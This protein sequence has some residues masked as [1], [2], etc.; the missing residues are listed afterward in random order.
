ML[1]RQPRY[2]PIGIDVGGASLKM[3]QLV[4]EGGAPSVATAA[5][6]VIPSGVE[7]AVPR[8][9][10]IQRAIADALRRHPFHGRAV[11]S[12]LGIRDFQMKSVRM[13]RMP[14]SDL[15]SAVKFEAQ[16]R[17]DLDPETSQYRFITA[18]EVR[19]G[20]ELKEEVIVFAVP[21]DV[22]QARLDLLEF[23]KL[24]PAAIDITP[25]AVARS[26]FRYLRRAED[27]HA[28]NVF[29]DV[30]LCGACIAIARGTEL[31]FL[32][33]IEVGG[34][35]FNSAVAESLNISAE[36]AAELRLRLMQGSQGRRAADKQAVQDEVRTTVSNA[37]RPLVE[38]LARD[39]QLCLRYFSV[40]FRG[41]RP[42]SL[43]FVGG[44]AHEPMLGAIIGE[45]V[46]VPCTI[47]H[48]LRGISRVSLIGGSDTRT[49]QP[50]WAV[51]CGLAMWGSE[52]IKP[53]QLPA[54]VSASGSVGA[55]PVQALG[56]AK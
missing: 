18:G 52:W 12:A 17:F 37:I 7:G 30:G 11:V 29:M 21:D 45:A 42:E 47:G 40:T 10:L 53:A 4:D 41:Q 50:A 5:H 31:M 1:K 46:D 8:E 15:A 48:P 3:L 19:H 6:Y 51:A 34:R 33:V 36:E 25:C 54:G 24:R 32:K 55:A 27:A 14:A 22:V 43:T 35:H 38:R 26:F 49:F 20:N 28:V 23:C 13:P 16:D 9:V 44:E 2:G 56:S 39:V